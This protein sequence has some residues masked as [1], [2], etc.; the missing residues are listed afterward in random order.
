MPTPHWSEKRFA[1]AAVL[2][3]LPCGY[4]FGAVAAFLLDGGYGIAQAW[5]VTVPLSLFAAVTVALLPVLRAETRF[6]ISGVGAIAAI[7]LHLMV[8]L[9]ADY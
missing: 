6:L 9:L 5:L 3:A 4:G 1:T 8:Q 2:A 7:D